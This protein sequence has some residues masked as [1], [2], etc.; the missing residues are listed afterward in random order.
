MRAGAAQKLEQQRF[1]L[2]SGMVGD[3]DEIGGERREYTIARG[4]RGGLDSQRGRV[5][6]VHAMNRKR[7][8]APRALGGTELRP[9]PGIRRESMV[10][11][12]GVER[13]PACGS[14]RRERV[15]ERHR[16]ATAGQSDRD[17]Q[18]RGIASCSPR[19][20][21]RRRGRERIVDRKRDRQE[22]G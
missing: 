21:E 18:R 4:T 20:D 7:D 15:Q 8:R 14:R 2:V 9:L 10:D 17:G 6:H 11:M 5:V 12:R 3:R 19:G 1:R 16:I 13:D 22:S